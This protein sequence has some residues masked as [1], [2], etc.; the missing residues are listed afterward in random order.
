MKITIADWVD[1]RKLEQMFLALVADIEEHSGAFPAPTLN[2]LK[3]AGLQR[4]EIRHS[5]LLAFFLDPGQAHGMAD[6]VIK[7]LLRRVAPGGGAVT[8]PFGRLACA[9]NGYSDLQVRREMMHV[10]VLAWSESC[11]FLLAI[12]AKVDASQGEDQLPRYRERLEEAFPDYTRELLFLTVDGASPNDEQWTA[13]KWSD[14]VAALE[15]ARNRKTGTMS[16]QAVFAV[17][18]YV[19]LLKSEVLVDEV[20]TPLVAI[21][22]QIYSRHKKAIDLIVEYGA[23]SEFTEAADQFFANN[24]SV[25]KISVGPKRAAFL[26]AAI[27][28]AC[29]QA[30]F[31]TAEG[32]SYWGQNAAIIMWFA[33]DGDKLALVVE[34]GPW[35]S[36]SRQKIV[37]E[38][39]AEVPAK[40]RV[41]TKKLTPVYSRIWTAKAG[42]TNG[43]PGIDE[44]REKMESLYGSL[45]ESIPRLAAIIGAQGAAV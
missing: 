44:I 39:K 42:F 37:V 5:N 18:Q 4:H 28:Q 13:I 16:E 23:V 30:G 3:A 7:Q 26:P 21:C 31:V 10:D 1:P 11:R 6:E 43:E 35:P 34:V 33:Y 41:T 27:E 36:P 15:N 40:G 32:S 45:K 17:D 38:L 22:R 8:A 24:A 29:W 20:N 12:E 25:S 2:L 9:L 14:V 19:E